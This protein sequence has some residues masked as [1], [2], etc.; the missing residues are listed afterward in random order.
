MIKGPITYSFEELLEYKSSGMASAEQ[1]QKLRD[2][3]EDI[4]KQPILDVT[5]KKLHS[6]LGTIHDYMSM[7]FIGGLIPTRPTDFLTFA[8]TVI[9]IPT[10]TTE[11]TRPKYTRE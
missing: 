10:R 9:R 6:H 11:F 3:A 5:Q 7:G 4:L 1:L 8:A 2:E